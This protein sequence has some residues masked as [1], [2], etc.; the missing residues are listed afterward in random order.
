MATTVITTATATVKHGSTDVTAQIMNLS[1]NQNNSQD[2]F[3]VLGSGSAFPQTD[4][5][6]EVSFDFL[7]DD[8][9]GLYGACNTLIDT[10]ASAVWTIT[11]GDTKWTA[12]MYVNGQLGLTAPADG[13]ITCSVSLLSDY[14]VVADAP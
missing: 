3:K 1:I 14:A 9:T 10:G 5:S 2:R 6:T 11:L 7:F 12:T 8:E 13:P 4:K